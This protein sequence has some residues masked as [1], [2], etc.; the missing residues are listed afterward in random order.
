MTKT[1]FFKVTTVLTSRCKLLRIFNLWWKYCMQ[2]YMFSRFGEQQ[3]IKLSLPFLDC[4]NETCEREQLYF[5][6]SLKLK[7]SNIC[8]IWWFLITA[9]LSNCIFIDVVITF[10]PSHFS[11]TLTF[12]IMMSDVVGFSFPAKTL[13][14]SSF[15]RKT[16]SYIHVYIECACACVCVGKFRVICGKKLSTVLMNLLVST[17]ENNIDFRL[18]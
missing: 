7:N 13:I 15:Q 17:T 9:D 6:F 5:I 4:G 8:I 14:T 3:Y 16:I 18:L 2:R 10:C 1:I 11:R 12:Y